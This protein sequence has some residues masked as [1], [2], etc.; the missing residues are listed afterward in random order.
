[1]ATKTKNRIGEKN[2]DL[3]TG[4]GHVTSQKTEKI[5]ISAPKMKLLR[6]RLVGESPLM[7]LRFSQK[8]IDKMVATQEAGTQ[9]NSRKKRDAR[10]FQADYEA[11]FYRLPD[12]SPGFP[13]GSIRS[14][15]I[16][17]CRMAS[18]KMT[19]AK[20]AIFCIADA[21]DIHSRVPLVRVH[22]TPEINKA[23]VRNANGNADIRIRPLWQ[24]WHIDTTIRFDM[25]QFSVSDVYNL[26]MRAGLQVGL[27]EGRPDSRASS[28]IGF[29]LFSVE[30]PDQPK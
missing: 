6:V 18:F 3:L 29:G 23:A 19:H 7:I 22:G 21:L 17:A 15:C 1:M 20:L 24:K 16:S 8:S 26:L 13:A 4:E 12:G 5:T 10:D 27:G 11:A 28:G 2:G 30:L 9:S 25:D 14:A